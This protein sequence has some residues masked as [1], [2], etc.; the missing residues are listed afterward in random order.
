MEIIITILPIIF[1]LELLILWFCHY[2]SDL[3]FRVFCSVTVLICFG[4][5][6]VVTM[7]THDG[8]IIHEIIIGAF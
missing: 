1:M 7:E 6:S 5:R 2:Y 3:I 4:K 8:E